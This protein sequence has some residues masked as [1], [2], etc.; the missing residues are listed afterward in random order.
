MALLW[1]ARGKASAPGAV[2]TEAAGRVGVELPLTG[3][4]LIGS[5][6]TSLANAKHSY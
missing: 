3:A 2:D 4:A 1:R 5:A 6:F